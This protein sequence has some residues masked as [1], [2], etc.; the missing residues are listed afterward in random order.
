[1]KHYWS[2]F[3]CSSIALIGVLLLVEFCEPK[4][5][6]SWMILIISIVL[7]VL[8]AQKEKILDEE[9][10]HYYPRIC[11]IVVSILVAGIVF[12]IVE[13]FS[14]LFLLACTNALVVMSKILEKTKKDYKSEN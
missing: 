13:K 12:S 8:E 10:K 3:I 2:C 1:M 4:P 5:I 9:G 14:I 11:I 7:I 6:F